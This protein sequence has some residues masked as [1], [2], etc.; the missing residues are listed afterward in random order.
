[1]ELLKTY[2]EN[3]GYEREKELSKQLAEIDT[4]ADMINHERRHILVAYKEYVDDLTERELVT[5]EPRSATVLRREIFLG[6]INKDNWK[7]WASMDAEE[8]A[9]LIRW[10]YMLIYKSPRISGEGLYDAESYLTTLQHGLELF[11]RNLEQCGEWDD[12]EDIE[13][14]CLLEDINRV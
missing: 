11:K 4:I 8:V 9:N 6:I 2:S 14:G 1:M 10:N 3:L 7:T 13:V 5:H 12:G